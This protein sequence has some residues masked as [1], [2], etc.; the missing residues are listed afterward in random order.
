MMKATI[1]S[2]LGASIA[3]VLTLAACRTEPLANQPPDNTNS[4]T[5]SS[6]KSSSA[7]VESATVESATE[8]AGNSAAEKLPKPLAVEHLPNAIRLHARVIS[9]GQPEGEAG[10]KELHDLGIKTVIS[11]DGAKPQLALAE[12]Y[13][14][15]YVHL[16]HGYN[17][18]PATRATELAKAVRDLE[19]PIY[20]H[21]HH[22]KHRSP[23]AATVAC[24]ATG[25]LDPLA[26]TS[27]LK[28]AGTSENYQGLF[29]SAAAARRID[30]AILDALE[31][32]FSPIA[33]LPPFAEAMV[34][35][36]LTFDH[37][38]RFT[39]TDW[40]PLPDH[41]DLD[42]AHEALLLTEHFTEMLRLESVAKEPEAFRTLL[43]Q[44]AADAQQLQELLLKRRTSSVNSDEINQRFK[45]VSENCTNCHRQFRDVPL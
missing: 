31:S 14:L 25:L 34:N 29:Q 36:D 35:L 38:K 33:Q 2:T 16:P 41:P 4:A 39:T 8:A 32:E 23:A 42:P 10:F 22:G 43:Q 45:R 24:V 17:G 1:H 28:L 18:I 11:V 27:V 5:N 15:R 21:C 7:T 37:L 26:A 9:G 6:A 30:N 13:G 40:K 19:G 12:K 3:L 20:I 44:S